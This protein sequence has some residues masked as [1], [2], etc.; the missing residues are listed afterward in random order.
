MSFGESVLEHETRRMIFNH[1][2]AHPGV[3]FNILK[4][5]FSLT[6]G[7]LRY[8]IN[9]LER[10]EKITFGLE[11]GKRLYF[12]HQNAIPI[13][14]GGGIMNS[15]NGQPFKLSPAQEKLLNTIKFNPRISQKELIIRTGMKRFTVVNNLKKLL[16]FEIVKKTPN[17]KNVYYEYITNEQLKYEMLKGL[18]IKLLKKEIDEQT[19]LQLKRQLE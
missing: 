13:P 2:L 18:V 8:H 17:G 14:G 9:Y 10:T 5:V 4:K 16:K 11:K 3:S 6:D 15:D 7:T 1:I 19:F 12:P